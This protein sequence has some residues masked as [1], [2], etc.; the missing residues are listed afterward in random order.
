MNEIE[1]MEGMP[2]VLD[3]AIHVNA[4]VLAGIAMDGGGGIRD[5]KLVPVR[6]DADAVARHDRDLRK[7]RAFGLPALRAAAYVIVRALR[8]DRHLDGI[9]TA[10]ARKGPAREIRR[11]GFRTLI[12]ARVN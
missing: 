4:A 6:R 8:T 1:A 10:V 11:S 9:L 2:G 12:H 3:A 7:Q 5:L